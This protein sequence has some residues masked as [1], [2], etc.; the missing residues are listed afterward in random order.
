MGV[1]KPRHFHIPRRFHSASF[2]SAGL[3]RRRP[4]TAARAPSVGAYLYIVITFT[5]TR[6]L[7]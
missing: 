5:R 6:G 7:H 1:P 3:E 4:G 2:W